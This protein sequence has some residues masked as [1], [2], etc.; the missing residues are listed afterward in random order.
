M[1]KPLLLASVLLAGCAAQKPPIVIVKHDLAPPPKVV[2][3]PD[4]M[5]TLLPEVQ[6]A[7]MRNDDRPIHVG[8]LTVYR[9]DP[10][11][12][13][14]V[15]CLPL[16][17]TQIRLADDEQI[18]RKGD[19]AVG[20]PERW[21][22]TINPRS[23]MVRPKATSAN[24]WATGPQQGPPLLIYAADQ[25]VNTNLIIQTNR[26]TYT[27]VLH[28]AKPPTRA[29]AWFYPETVRAEQAARQ[30]AITEAKQ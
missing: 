1:I 25:N 29:I 28:L 23:V 6:D 13:Y 17:E 10:N 7:I 24:I 21:A 2:I 26:R 27:V 11:Q 18:E 4:P 15:N 19:V 5:V 9:Y 20:D 8:I 22:L 16:F 3:P 30:E 12:Q 14:A